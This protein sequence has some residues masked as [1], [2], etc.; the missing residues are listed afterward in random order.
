MLEKIRDSEISSSLPK[1]GGDLLLSTKIKVLRGTCTF[2]IQATCL[3]VGRITEILIAQG[4]SVA[5]VC[6]LWYYLAVMQHFCL[7]LVLAGTGF[8]AFFLAQRL[9]AWRFSGTLPRPAIKQI[10]SV[11]AMPTSLS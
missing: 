11:A 9:S 6:S 1:S 10:C 5:G 8:L 3:S 4:F 7:S 2:Q